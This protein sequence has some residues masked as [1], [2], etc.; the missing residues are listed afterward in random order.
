MITVKNVRYFDTRRGIGYEAKTNAGSIWN[1]GA[2]GA[3]YF[4]ANL[5]SHYKDFSH[6]SEDDLE[7]LINQYERKKTQ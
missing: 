4:V 2:G 7:S 5:E 3:T 1:D 6:L